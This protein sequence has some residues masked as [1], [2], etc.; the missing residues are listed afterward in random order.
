MQKAEL[1]MKRIEDKTVL[2]DYDLGVL[3]TLKWVRGGPDP[4]CGRVELGSRNV[5]HTMKR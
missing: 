1:L 5:A 2:T 3:H 4:Y